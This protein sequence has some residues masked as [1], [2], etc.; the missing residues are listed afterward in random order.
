MHLPESARY[1]ALFLAGH[2]LHVLNRASLSTQLVLSGTK[3]RSEWVRANLFNLT[4]RF[5]VHARL[6]RTGWRIRT[7]RRTRSA[8]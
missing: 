6:F 2:G 7:P 8:Q 5:F 4:I 3:T 1:G